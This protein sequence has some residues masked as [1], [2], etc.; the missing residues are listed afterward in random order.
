MKAWDTEIS[1]LEYQGSWG[2][3]LLFFFHK[4]SRATWPSSKLRSGGTA[5][6]SLDKWGTLC[7]S[8]APVSFSTGWGPPSASHHPSLSCCL[9]LLICP[10]FGLSPYLSRDGPTIVAGDRRRA[11]GQLACAA[12]AA[13][14]AGLGPWSGPSADSSGASAWIEGAQG[15]G[16]SEDPSLY[17][18][19][20]KHQMSWVLG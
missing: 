20:G 17:S 7:A 2:W 11:S 6:R 15:L 14:R 1:G 12:V 13:S 10:S 3:L 16:S 18:L 9:S 8:R 5:G 19:L 4:V